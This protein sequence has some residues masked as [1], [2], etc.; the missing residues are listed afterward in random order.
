MTNNESAIS[1]ALLR[2]LITA[3]FATG[4]LLWN[5]RRADHFA[6]SWSRPSEHVCNNWNARYGGTKALSSA[7]KF[8][9]LC[10][11]INAR[12]IYAHRAIWAL[13][14][15]A[16]PTNFIDHI[17]GIPGDNRVVNLRDVPH[18]DNLR[19]ARLSMANSTG[20]TGVYFV[21]RR[22]KWTARI[23]VDGVEKSFGYHDT[24]EKA[25]AARHAAAARFGFHPN[26][27]RSA[28]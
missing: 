12:L 25:V 8:G 21:P 13:A 24:Y 28:L 23:T 16:W 1:V 9:H 14:N 26:H 4:D 5:V 7:D 3:N 11:R 15:G 10:G 20:C 6:D 27:G 19:N 2:E 22:S 18:K 17:N